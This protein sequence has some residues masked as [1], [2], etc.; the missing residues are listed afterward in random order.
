MYVKI[1]VP[2]RIQ[3]IQEMTPVFVDELVSCVRN[4]LCMK[5]SL[6]EM[7]FVQND[8]ADTLSFTCH[9]LVIY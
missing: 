3:S 2:T 7:V 4:G 8:L 5:W 9:L 6:Y 1:Q